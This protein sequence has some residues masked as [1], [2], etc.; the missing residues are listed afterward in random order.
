MYAVFFFSILTF[1]AVKNP[2]FFS[3]LN[4]ML[5]LC[6]APYMLA[7]SAFLPFSYPLSF[8]FRLLLL[9]IVFFFLVF[10]FPMLRYLLLPECRFFICSFAFF[11][12]CCLFST[13]TTE[14]KQSLVPIYCPSFFFLLFFLF[15]LCKVCLLIYDQL[16]LF[17][18]NNPKN[19]KKRKLSKGELKKQMGEGE[20]GETVLEINECLSFAFKTRR[21]LADQAN[22]LSRTPFGFLYHKRTFFFPAKCS[23]TFTSAYVLF[24]CVRCLTT[25]VSVNKSSFFLFVLRLSSSNL[26]SIFS[27]HEECT[28]NFTVRVY[29]LLLGSFV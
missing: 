2:C 26:N 5:F 28:F 27:C 12:F 21:V 19:L 11:F 17:N 10:C 20:D 14:N 24:L 8:S 6:C 22:R 4:S 15:F 25:L 16:A 13:A 29:I 7:V 9:K 3:F 23:F 1:I 18:T